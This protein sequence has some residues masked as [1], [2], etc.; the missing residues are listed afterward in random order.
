[1]QFNENR[2][3]IEVYNLPQY[4]PE[5]NAAELIWKYTRKVGAH[6]KCFQ[7]QD[8]ILSTLEEVFKDVKKRL[9]RI[10]DYLK[11]FL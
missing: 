8:E 1:M 10:R 6:N 2:N 9:S 5:L 7:N 11:P 4:C 3:W